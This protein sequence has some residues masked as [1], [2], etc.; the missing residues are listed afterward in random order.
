[1]N[2]TCRMYAVS[3]NIQTSQNIF[4]PIQTS[5]V[6]LLLKR[7]VKP[8]IYMQC[9]AADFN[10]RYL[11]LRITHTYK[12]YPTDVAL[13][14]F[15]VFQITCYSYPLEQNVF[16]VNSSILLYN[17]I[18]FPLQEQ[19]EASFFLSCHTNVSWLLAIV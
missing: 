13:N 12:I 16:L 8:N 4:D 17:E 9:S 10:A 11:Y 6:G 14:A 18:R 5:R 19:Q 15:C 2:N 1:M 7:G 3:R